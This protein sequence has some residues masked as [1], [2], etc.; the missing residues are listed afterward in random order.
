VR[1]DIALVGARLAAE[2]PAFDAWYDALTPQADVIL[3]SGHADLGENVR[4]LM[5]KGTFLP[6]KYVLWV[7]NACDTFAYVDR[8]LAD[9]RAALNPDDIHGTKYLDTVSTIL[10]GYFWTGPPTA[11]SFLDA[12]VTARDPTPAPKTY[13][14]IFTQLDPEQITV[15]TGEEDNEFAPAMFS[16]AFSPGTGVHD[17]GPSTVAGDSP[18]AALPQPSG[19]SCSAARGAPAESAGGGASDAAFVSTIAVALAWLRRRVRAAGEKL[20]THR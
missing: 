19:G 11:I 16:Q 20:G 10:G 5:K 1:I 9:R 8:T 2:G 17:A 18:A 3:Y 13:R 14:E 6:G 15:V 12:M 7:E 4:T